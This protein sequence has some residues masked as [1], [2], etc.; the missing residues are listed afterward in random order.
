MYIDIIVA[1]I[2]LEFGNIMQE[3]ILKNI[4]YVAIFNVLSTKKLKRIMRRSISRSL[5]MINGF[6]ELKCILGLNS[7]CIR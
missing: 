7:R 5:F 1:Y 6:D 4:A 3:Y 2:A